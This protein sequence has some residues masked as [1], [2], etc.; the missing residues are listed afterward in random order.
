MKPLHATVHK[1]LHLHGH[2]S[3]R[4]NEERAGP[5]RGDYISDTEITRDRGQML[6]VKTEAKVDGQ[7][8]SEALIL[9]KVSLKSLRAKL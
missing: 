1:H 9:A 8:V 5:D 2:P 6:V 4:D 7:V 3:A